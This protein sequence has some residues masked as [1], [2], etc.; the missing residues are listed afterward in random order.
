M[1]W[2]KV[3]FADAMNSYKYVNSNEQKYFAGKLLKL[4]NTMFYI[5]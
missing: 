4:K 1:N 2:I 3:P 5:G